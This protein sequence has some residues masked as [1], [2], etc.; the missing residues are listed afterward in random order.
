MNEIKTMLIFICIEGTA[1]EDPLEVG[2]GR[3]SAGESHTEAGIIITSPYKL[4]TPC[5]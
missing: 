2:G 5:T 4:R 1:N 3:M